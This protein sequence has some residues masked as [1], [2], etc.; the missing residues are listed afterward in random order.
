MTEKDIL[1]EHPHGH[2][3]G[4]MVSSHLK[5]VGSPLFPLLTLKE[6][7]TSYYL[8]FVLAELLR[9]FIKTDGP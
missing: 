5:G 4:M 8:C 2:N 3:V 1:A 9:S 7:E 6:D